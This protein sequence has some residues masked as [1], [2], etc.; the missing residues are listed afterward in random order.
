MNGN[1]GIEIKLIYNMEKHLKE[2]IDETMAE[3]INMISLID[4][5]IITELRKS[6][7]KHS[8]DKLDSIISEWKNLDDIEICELL[9]E[10]NSSAE[11]K[12]DKK[13]GGW[14][15]FILFDKIT[16]DSHYIISVG[17]NRRFNREEGHYIYQLV[18]NEFTSENSPYHD[19]RIDYSDERDRDNKYNFLLVLMNDTGTINFH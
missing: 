3:E 12:P 14:K 15:N 17:K 19:L 9:V 4:A 1:L 10:Y 6:L 8:L 2:A 16:L 5:E 13:T 7:K 18:L 11:D